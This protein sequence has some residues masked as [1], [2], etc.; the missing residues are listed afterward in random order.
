MFKLEIQK[1]NWIKDDGADDPCDLCAHGT[2]CI[3]IG[4]KCLT[5]EQVTVSAGAIFLLRSLTENH[6]AKATGAGDA[7][8][9]LPCCANELFEN[10][11]NP[12]RVV[13]ITCPFGFDFSVIHENGYVKIIE[14]TC[15][16]LLISI[17][18]YRNEVYKFADQVE[19]FHSESAPKQFNNPESEKGYQAMFREWKKLR[20]L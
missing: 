17:D 16:E 1:L 4:E 8:R 6:I 9:I 15:G 11:K 3:T 12:D 2:V 18:E 7:E 14:D 19:K 13:I 5:T 20:N 10:E